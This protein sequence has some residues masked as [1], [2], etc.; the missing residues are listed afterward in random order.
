MA[1]SRLRRFGAKLMLVTGGLLFG[2]LVAEI[3]L[4]IIGYSYPIFYETDHDRGYAPIPNVEG[5][6]W[7]E[8]KTYVK[9]N[10]AGFRDREHT[11]SKPEHT[12]RIAVIG[13]SF[14]EARQVPM[15][16]AFWSVMERELPGCASFA[17]KNVEVFNFGVGGYG[18][19]SELM[20]LRQRVWAYSP[21]I[22]LL[23][24]TIYNDVTDNYAPFKGAEEIPY[25]KFEND[26][27]VF[28]TSFRDSKK[29]RRLSSWWF[30]AW[31]TL[32]NS[33]RFIQVVHHGQFAF[34][35]YM[36][37]IKERRRLAE[38]QRQQESAETQ[39]VPVSNEKLTDQFGIHNIIYREPDDAGWIEAWRVT[40]GLIALM[41]DEVV[42]EGAKFTVA[43][44]T[45]D[46][47]AYPDQDVREA[48]AKSL[49]VSDLWYPNRRLRSFAEQRGVDFFDLAEPMQA[50][51]AE[52]GTY[53][54]G[55][56]DQMGS[57]HW[58]EAG[59]RLAGELLSQKLC[60][61]ESP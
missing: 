42:E 32:H 6:F 20:T 50:F 28:D 4:R 2:C 44:V 17:G 53:L 43:T 57:G 39:V 60:K 46:I 10:S 37:A 49:G 30:N 1:A 41:H 38:I 21:D 59:H 16:S 13:D 7:V 52:T 29:Y 58:N 5:W 40:E 33:S 18:T 19:A 11:I 45:T 61:M 22:V 27:L 56:G 15:E 9:M 24:F 48:R 3:A 54:H 34:R 23:T 8:N 14:S 31:I 51:A 25:F 35:T 55:F 36:S 47:Q 12:I 26:N